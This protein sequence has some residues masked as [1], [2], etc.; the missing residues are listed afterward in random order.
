MKHKDLKKLLKD[1]HLTE[2]EKDIVLEIY[3]ILQKLEEVRKK[4]DSVNQ[5]YN[6]TK[7]RREQ[8]ISTLKVLDKDSEEKTR[9]K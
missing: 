2:K 6:R 1:E 9:K 8:I 4:K 5:S 3:N 7:D